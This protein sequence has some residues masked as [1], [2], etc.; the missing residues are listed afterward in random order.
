MKKFELIIYTSLLFHALVASSSFLMLNLISHDKG[1]DMT[2]SFLKDCNSDYIMWMQ[3]ELVAILL[4]E[5][6]MLLNAIGAIYLVS[7]A[8]KNVNKRN[9]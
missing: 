7:C 5:I 1:L 9:D 6:P 3:N 2:R 4:A 8:K